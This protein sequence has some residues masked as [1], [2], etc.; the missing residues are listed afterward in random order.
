MDAFVYG[1][2]AEYIPLFDIELIAGRNFDGNIASDSSAV[3]VNEAMVKALKW[4]HPLQEHL[5]WQRDTIG[6]GAKV[7]GVVK[8]YH[9]LSLEH[10]VQ[11]MLVSLKGGYLTNVLVKLSPYDL[12]DK[13][14]RIRNSWAKVFPDRPFEY[15]FVDQDVAA[16]YD[17]HQR[18]SKIM[19][20]S[21]IFAILIASLGLFGLAGVNAVN[22][23]KEIGIRK[24][25]GA[26][27]AGIFVLL[28]KQYVWLALIAFALA[29][30]LSWY[31]MQKW[32]GTFKFAVQVGWETFAFSLAMGLVVALLTVSYHAIRVA[33]INP[34]STLKQ[35]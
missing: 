5:N 1:V 22:R 32:L 30:P 26:Q 23:T 13:V 35:E 3:I 4:E 14:E 20:L 33:L 25:M 21:T 29:V 17:M 34:A 10:E 7:I 27:V 19:G 9:F 15:T 28:N 11:P 6:P 18:W 8:D 16:Q 2:D 24:V 12:P 31:V